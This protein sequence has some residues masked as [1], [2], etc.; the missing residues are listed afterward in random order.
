MKNCSKCGQENLDTDQFCKSCGASLE[1]TPQAETTAPAENAT[2]AEET[3]PAENVAPVEETKNEDATVLVNEEPAQ[4]NPA[5]QQTVAPM[6]APMMGQPQQTIPPQGMAPMGAPGMPPQ[7]MAPMG[8]TQMPTPGMAPMGT[9]QMPTPGMAPM[10]T[11][12][13]PPQGMAPMGT[14]GMA[15]QQ[16][17]KPKKEKKQ[18][19]KLSGGALAGIIIGVIVVL[20]G[21]G[22]GVFFIIKSLSPDEDD[23]KA[24]LP[25]EIT[26]YV[27]DGEEYESTVESV[28]IKDK[29]SNTELECEIV[30]VDE[31]F[32]RTLYYELELEK[33][34]GEWEVD[35][36]ECDDD[37]E[38]IKLADTYVQAEAAEAGYSEI[39]NIVNNTEKGS[40]YFEYEFDVNGQ[41]TYATVTGTAELEV[42]FDS[43]YYD[44]DMPTYYSYAYVYDYDVECEWNIAGSYIEDADEVTMGITITDLGD[45]EYQVDFASSEYGTAS[46]TGYFYSYSNSA[47]L[48]VY[49]ESNTHGYIDYYL[50]FTPN[51]FTVEVYSED[52]SEDLTMKPG[53]F[54]QQEEE[55]DFNFED[56]ID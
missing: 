43:Y 22:V 51:E 23:I 41:S 36:F 6:G 21:I 16:P 40:S 38:E 20:A 37:E 10:G 49:T 4:P 56:Y 44:D 8:T 24:A 55:S 30:L 14:P 2:P 46:D 11:T 7:G 19:K 5:P 3:A 29:K 12:Q 32:E 45:E 50:Y 25:K 13:M 1:Q 35:K 27:L 18:G 42:Y 39:T 26:N 17:A 31:N 33:D 9:T 48:Y 53:E 54:S 34:G 15:P 52:G 47:E 28:V